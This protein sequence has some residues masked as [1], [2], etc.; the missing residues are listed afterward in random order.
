MSDD[1]VVYEMMKYYEKVMGESHEM[2]DKLLEMQKAASAE[3]TMNNF[4]I[5]KQ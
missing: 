2:S 4:Q 5:Y 3:R 1:E